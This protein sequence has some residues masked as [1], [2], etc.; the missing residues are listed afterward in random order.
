MLIGDL[1][2]QL[3]AAGARLSAAGLVRASE[4][5]V[6]ARIDGRRCLVT[7]TG[8]VTGRLNGADMVEVPL[9]GGKVPP[10][11]SSEIRLH[12]EIYRGRPDVEA[13]VHA[14]PP[15]VLL[16]SREGR[17]PDPGFLDG[18]EAWFGRVVD[19]PYFEEGST[20]LARTAAAALL[21]ATA[22]VLSDHGAVTVGATV[23]NALRRMLFLERAA[24][25]T[26]GR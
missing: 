8:G 20:A 3:V 2:T 21:E 4:G 18:E 19:V 25:R 15:R 16:L 7:P 5:N 1:H 11:A 12:I 6:S 14:H 10:R 26:N 23:E 13:I 17:L 9:D 22:C 24:V